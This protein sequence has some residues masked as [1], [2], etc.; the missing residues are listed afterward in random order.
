MFGQAQSGCQ[1]DN[2]ER[3]QG[4]FHFCCRMGHSPKNPK[5]TGVAKSVK[6]SVKKSVA[7]STRNKR[8]TLRL[9]CLNDVD[10]RMDI[11]LWQ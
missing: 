6:K 11:E 5:A 10:T 3:P 2:K 8:F 4:C 7:K 1:E 9:F